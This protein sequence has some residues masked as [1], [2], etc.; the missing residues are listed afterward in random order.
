LQQFP[1]KER[2]SETGLDYFGARYYSSAQG[3]FTSPD[4]GNALPT[5]PQSWNR[6]RYARNNPLYYVDPDGNTDKPAKDQRINEAL[7][8]DATLL[9]AIKASNN[10][11]QRQFEIALERGTLREGN[12]DYWKL[13]GAAG[14]SIIADE[15]RGNPLAAVTFQPRA[16]QGVSPDL[17][18]QHPRD[19]WNP[20]KKTRGVIGNRTGHHC[21]QP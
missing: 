4:Q 19:C 13:M 18:R 9:E 16:L 11:S 21:D 12:P 15:R 17:L 8:T 1:S 2:D 10:F 5:D 20:I 3:R 6:Y 7:S 14:E